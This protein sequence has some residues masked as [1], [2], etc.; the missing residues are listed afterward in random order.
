MQRVISAEWVWRVRRTQASGKG[1]SGSG[2]W[3]WTCP[4]AAWVALAQNNV[5]S[6]PKQLLARVQEPAAKGQVVGRMGVG[7]AN[8]GV[9]IVGFRS[10]QDCR[11][12]N[13]ILTS[14]H[15]QEPAAKGQVVGR[16]GVGV[17]SRGVGGLDTAQPAGT[18]VG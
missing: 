3:A 7:V 4:A 11:E 5:E 12:P 17:A 14:A 2:T 9:G 1:S 8:R 18:A 6:P 16:M 13:R 15:P 10:A